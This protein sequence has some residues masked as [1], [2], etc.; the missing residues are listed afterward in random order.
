[1]RGFIRLFITYSYWLFP[2]SGNFLRMPEFY[3]VIE[4][5]KSYV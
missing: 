4:E 1:M 5:G 3:L 2:F